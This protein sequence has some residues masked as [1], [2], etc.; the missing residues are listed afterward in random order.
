MV[1]PLAT[2]EGVLGDLA[3]RGLDLA[4]PWLCEIDGANLL[5]AATVR[6]HAG[7]SAAIQRRQVHNWRNVLIHLNG[8]SPLQGA[9]RR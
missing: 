3:E 9:K 4:R 1:V 5:N 2:V 8:V 6:S 7:A